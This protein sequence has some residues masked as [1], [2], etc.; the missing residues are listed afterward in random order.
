[1][2]PATTVGSAKGRSI[3]EFTID[4]PRKLSLTRTQAI[5][6]PVTTLTATTIT[7][8]DE[9]QL[10][11]RDCLRGGHRRPERTEAAI[12]RLSDER[13]DRD[14]DDQT[15]VRGYEAAPE[16]GAPEMRP[17]DRPRGRLRSGS[18]CYGRHSVATPRSCRTIDVI[19][20]I[21]PGSPRSWRR[22][23]YRDR[24]TRCWP[25]SQPPMLGSSTVNSPDGVGN[26]ALFLA[27]TDLVH[28]PVAA[29]LPTTAVPVGVHR[30][31][32][33]VLG[34]RRGVGRRRGGRLDQDRVVGDDVVDLLTGLLGLDRVALVGE[35]DVALA[36]REGGQGI[37]RATRLGDGV[38][39][40][41][42]QESQRLG[43]GLALPRSERRRPPAGS[44]SRHPS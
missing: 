29:R 12:G 4:L 33:E 22:C 31:F 13:R 3:T 25:F 43:G 20:W 39:E 36:A 21:R 16:G 5:A 6:V 1:M 32:E 28:G 11:G 17:F 34:L 40:Q 44:T 2:I 24:R 41:R 15:Q 19:R 38:L 8:S 9:G 18:W 7:A 14:Q 23:R 42:L 26:L 10:Q 30:N 35:Q 37:T 27:S